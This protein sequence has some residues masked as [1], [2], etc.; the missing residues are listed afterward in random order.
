MY[1]TLM[2]INL[3]SGK[4]DSKKNILSACEILSNNGYNLN[5]YFTKEKGD[6]YRH[7]KSK[8]SRYDLILAVGGD[9]TINE[10]TSAMMKLKKKPRL[11][12]FPSGTM[13][14]FGS[15]FDLSNNYID[16][17]NKII[18]P[19]IKEFD[20]NEFNDS[21]FNYVA[22]FGSFTD[23]SYK[24]KREAKEA[25]G[26]FAYILEGFGALSN[27]KGTKT[28]IKINNKVEEL[29]VLFG[30]IFSGNRV[31]GMKLKGNKG[32]INDGLVNILLVE[33]TPNI[34]DYGNYLALLSNEKNKYLHWYSSNEVELD[35]EDEIKWT[36]DGE[37]VNGKKHAHILVHH[38]ALEM[39]Y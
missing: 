31:A 25:L 9:G 26:S 20:I 34:L 29:D 17:A 32:T 15:N 28:K 2:I 35:F 1:K 14:D 8:G 18:N 24:T 30:L 27:I 21:Y 33:Y 4:I 11:A 39:L 12:Y 10:V 23:V 16:I 6:A 3:K 22:G 7:V 19:K 5:L 37:E 36:L 38:N 13:N